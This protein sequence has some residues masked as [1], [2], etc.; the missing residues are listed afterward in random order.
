MCLYLIYKKEG[1]LKMGKYIYGVINGSH[2]IKFNESPVSDKGEEAYTISYQD[3]SA[4]VSDLLIE[5]YTCMSRDNLAR[6]LVRHQR[7]I[8]KIMIL[9]HTIIPM[10]LGTFA[11]DEAEVKNILDTGYNPIKEIMEK[12]TNKI[13]IDI[14]ATWSDFVSVLKGVGEEKEIKEAKDKLLANQKITI[15]DQIKM[16]NMVQEALN[17]NRDIHAQGIQNRL[18]A[19]SWDFKIHELMDEKMVINAAF[20]I[21]SAKQKK[22]EKEIEEMDIEFDGRLNFRCVGPLPLYSFYTLEIMKMEFEDIDWARKILGLSNYASKD[23][24]KKAYQK[25][26]ASTHPD[27]NPNMPDIER[28]FDDVTEAYKILTDY[29]QS[30]GQAGEREKYSFEKK[31]VKKNAILVTVNN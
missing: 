23:E 21:D 16:G 7:V 24:I 1:Q 22:F 15:D 25:A 2:A 14:C 26:A 3:I 30:C 29:I 27:I 28:K 17:K 12:I 4:V 6:L 10:R 5:D 19:I 18:G 11:A 13:E 8:E 9:K 31:E 20:L